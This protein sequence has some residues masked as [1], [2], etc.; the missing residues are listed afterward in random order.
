MEVSPGLGVAGG[1]IPLLHP[2]PPTALPPVC[3]GRAHPTGPPGPF[4]Q[5]LLQNVPSSVSLLGFNLGYSTWYVT[6]G[7]YLT[8]LSLNSLRCK[9]CPSLK[10]SDI[11]TELID[12]KCRK[13]MG[14]GA[15]HFPHPPEA[16]SPPYSRV[17]SARLPALARGGEIKLPKNSSRKETKAPGSSLLHFPEWP[18]DGRSRPG[19]GARVPPA[20]GRPRLGHSRAARLSYERSPGRGLLHPGQDSERPAL[21]C[22]GLPFA[23][24][25]HD[26]SGSHAPALAEDRP[27][28]LPGW[29][30]Q[31]GVCRG[32]RVSVS[33]HWACPLVWCA[34]PGRF[35]SVCGAPGVCPAPSRARPQ[36]GT[37]VRRRPAGSSRPS[38][39]DG[40]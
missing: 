15:G 2:P 8:S 9:W 25:E 22:G 29:R 36:H 17:G 20:G 35:P 13:V 7:F 23:P 31:A 24:G 39:R 6:S 32:D 38:G 27:G 26:A 21:A 37:R 19:T 12:V 14:P 4:A 34:W 28:D 3:W 11:L 40:A 18:A 30:A 16:Q 5:S 33:V 1:R 10:R